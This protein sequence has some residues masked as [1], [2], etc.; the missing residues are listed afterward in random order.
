M[1][2]RRFDHLF[3][4]ICLAVER[5]VPR[6]QLWLELHDL[7]C[8]PEDLTRRTA[9]AFC[10]GPLQSFLSERGLHL[11]Q[12]SARRLRRAVRRFDPTVPTPEEQLARI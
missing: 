5:R 12:P 7:G 11:S 3:V 10:E 6:Y 4:E 8:D 2:R 9:L 1:G